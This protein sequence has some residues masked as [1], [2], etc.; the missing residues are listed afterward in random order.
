MTYAL[1][2]IA[3][4]AAAL[5]LLAACSS[6][7]AQQQEAARNEQILRLTDRVHTLEQ[8]NAAKDAQIRAL[9][10]QVGQP[11]LPGP[12]PAGPAMLPPTGAP[13]R[14]AAVSIDVPKTLAAKG[15]KMVATKDGQPALLIPGAHLFSPGHATL[16]KD[17]LALIRQIA[18]VI[19][20]QA[21]AARIRVEGH[22]DADPI[23]KSKAHYKSNQELSEARA[24][25]VRDALVK[26]G[27]LDAA[28]VEAAGYGDTHPVASNK[29][30]AGKRENRRV[31]LVI[32]GGGP[33]NE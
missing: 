7:R 6:Q 4:G 30:D 14:S 23:H 11:P 2:R 15:V 28:R 20:K 5:G 19:K 9:G 29:T 21:P 17:D 10:A 8:E 33:A 31:E 13:P 3:A 32:L 12:Q 27:K 22:T 25:A 18:E 16:S 1:H 24:K 26:E